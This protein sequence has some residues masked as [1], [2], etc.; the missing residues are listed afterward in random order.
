VSSIR[1]Y[2]LSVICMVVVCGIMQL[3][4]T[5]GPTGSVIKMI[6]GLIVT[7]VVINPL[8]KNRDLQWDFQINDINLDSEFAIAEGK[9]K[10][11]KMF[12]ELIKEKTQTYIL[13][14][15][16]AMGANISVE[17]QLQKD[18]PTVI[19]SVTVLG[20]VS[21]Y[22]KRQ[23]LDCLRLDLGIAEEDQIWIS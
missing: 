20:D 19:D 8:L 23:L 22:V 4:I 12:S 5:S 3:F 14:K 9:R 7:V 17:I 16:E 18:N 21:P 11:A 15:A 6:A 10:S 1:Q 13:N 2:L